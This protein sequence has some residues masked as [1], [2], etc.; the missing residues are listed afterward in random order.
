MLSEEIETYPHRRYNQLTGEWILVSPQRAK[1]PWLGK[2][3]AAEQELL[4]AHDPACYLCPGNRRAG[5][6]INPNYNGVYVFDNDFPALMQESPLHFSAANSLLRFNMASGVC[7]VVLFSPRHDLTIPELPISSI[8]ALVKEWIMQYRELSMQPSLKYIQVFE[9]KGAIMGCS[10]PHPH[11]QI[12]ATDFVPAEIEKED[13]CQRTHFENSGRS[14]LG[15]YLKEEQL[16]GERMVCGNEHFTVLVPF[17]ASWPYETL[18]I[19]HRPA[20]SIDALTEAEQH[21]FA[22]ILQ[23]LT[24]RYDNLF[25]VSFPYSSGIHQTPVN[26]I[27]R[28]WWHWHM[29][30][31]PPLL[32]S[33]TVKKFMV[34]YEMLAEAQRDITPEQAA[35]TLRACSTEHYK[36]RI[37]CN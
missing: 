15:D 7:R 10:N 5:K 17:W 24:I 30:F 23:E 19:P 37:L 12:W 9:N 14:L 8:E 28:P 27:D 2:Q 33:A 18:L 25:Q 13:K 3:E 31:Y 35:A 21:A 6:I 11:G 36:K 20:G 1:R 22:S 16:N 4:P 29:H 26:G 32:R 34:G